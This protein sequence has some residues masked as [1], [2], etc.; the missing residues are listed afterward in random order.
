MND[1]EVRRVRQA[2]PMARPHTSRSAPPDVSPHSEEAVDRQQEE[3]AEGFVLEAERRLPDDVAFDGHAGSCAKTD[4][5]SERFGTDEIRGPDD[6]EGEEDRRDGNCGFAVAEQSLDHLGCECEDRFTALRPVEPAQVSGVLQ[7]VVGV[8]RQEGFRLPAECG[9][10]GPAHQRLQSEL[11]LSQQR[12]IG[13]RS[14]L[15]SERVESEQRR[16]HED[17]GDERSL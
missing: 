1:S 16:V 8:A 5:R 4:P 9:G 13:H 11:G 15:E 12:R 14:P 10:T 6:E 3:E 17:A 7:V 2:P